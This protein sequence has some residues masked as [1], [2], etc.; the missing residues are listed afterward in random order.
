MLSFL[1]VLF[2]CFGYLFLVHTSGNAVNIALAF[3]RDLS[4][5]LGVFFDDTKESTHD[6]AKKEQGL[7]DAQ[8]WRQ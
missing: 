3:N 2:D 4:A 8:R 7:I 6:Q 5:S 1:D